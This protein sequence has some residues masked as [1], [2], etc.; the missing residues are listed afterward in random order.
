MALTWI[1]NRDDIRIAARDT[2]PAVRMA[3][4]LA[5]RRLAM[6]EVADF[7]D[8]GNPRLVLEAARAINDAPVNAALPRLAGLVTRRGMPDPLLH[9]VINANFRLGERNNALA[10]GNLAARGDI[11]TALRVESLECL[12]DWAKPSGRDRI[13]GLWRPLPQRPG[14]DAAEGLRENIDGIFTG[15]DKVRTVAAKVASKYAIK[16]VVPKLMEIAG[17]TNRS[18]S[19]R[20]ETLKALVA[21]PDEKLEKII[22]MALADKEPLVRTQGRRMLA[23]LDPERVVVE[24]KK[25]L[26]K[27]EIVDRQGAFEVLADVWYPG[28]EDLLT[29]WLQKLLDKQVPAEIQLDLLE[30]AAK[31]KTKAVTKL[32]KDYEATRSPKDHLAAW[33]ESMYGG[34]AELGKK[35]FFERSDVSCLRCHKIKGTGGDVGPDL[36]D[37]AAKQNREYLLESIVDPDRQIAKGYE[38][39]VLTLVDGKVKT[40][41]IKSEDKK[42]VRLMTPEG[43]IIVVPVAEIDTRS[44]GPSAMPADVMKH[45]SRKDLRDLVEYLSS[46]K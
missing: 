9:R 26:D 21:F 16:A 13:V 11:P 32:L 39:V 37:I 36:T 22:D 44:R 41:I 17:D 35:I 34:N 46:L 40:G 28:G 8:D 4:L 3:A 6:P 19:V 1:G 14:A 15:P 33:R 18:P 42:E 38:T 30:A 5:M 45:L 10:L 7:L 25:A 2:S 29:A 12:L 20:V 43:Q 24:L 23:K 27:G 31:H